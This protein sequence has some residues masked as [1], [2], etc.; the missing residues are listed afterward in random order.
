ML[1]KKSLLKEVDVRVLLKIAY[2]DF[3]ISILPRSFCPL[4]FTN[5]ISTI[6]ET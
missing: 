1:S 6:P 4:L 5:L 3:Y 2:E